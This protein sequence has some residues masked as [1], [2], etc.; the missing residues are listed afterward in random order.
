MVLHSELEADA[1][2]LLMHLRRMA[3][4][5]R[6]LPADK[7]DWTFAPPAPTP[8]TLAV[9]ALAWLQC[10]RQHINNPD[11]ASHQPVPEPPTEPDG[12]CTA[13]ELEADA[14]EEL[15]KGMTAED[16]AR[17]GQ[18]FGR[19]ESPM[20]V[21]GFVAHMI[22]NVI[23][24]NGQFATMYFALGLDGDGPYEAPFPNPIYKE[25]LGIG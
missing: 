6:D 12:I 10:D 2:I 15:L 25:L 8:R 7:W 20:N 1:F 24:K 11:I 13:M 5:L 19:S 16:L 22:Q 14:W 21:R 23:Y 9:H 3:R 4:N 17:E 18:Q